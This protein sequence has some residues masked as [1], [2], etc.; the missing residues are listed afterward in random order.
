MNDTF[1]ILMLEDNHD[2]AEIIFNL[3]K[4]NKFYFESKL[5]SDK[6]GFV[7]AL[8]DFDPA[9]ILCDNSMPRFSATEALEVIRQRAVYIPFILITGSASEEFAADIIKKG[10]DDFILK[11]RLA[12]L[13]A[14]IRSA[15]QKRK[16]EYEMKAKE[17]QIMF[18]AKLLSAVGQAIIVTDLTDAVTYWNSAAEKMYGWLQDEV[19][20]RCITELVPS[21]QNKEHAVAI[22]EHM[23]Q[24]NSWRGDLLVQKKDGST[25]PAFV[26]NSPVYDR[27]GKLSGIISVSNDISEQK[28]ANEE[29]RELEKQIMESKIQHQKMI[30]RA[31]IKAQEEERNRLG[32]ELHDNISQILA[33]TILYLGA[34]AKK[35]KEI[36]GL[37]K[38]PISSI[39]NSVNEIRLL[40]ARYVTPVKNINLERQVE[41]LISQ[42]KLATSIKVLFIYSVV[43][44]LNDE[45]KLN[46]FRIVQ[47][48]VNNIIKHAA[49]GNVTI[50][51]EEAGGLL[52]VDIM[53][54]GRGFDPG[55][56]RNGIGISNMINRAE[57]FNGTFEIESS[58]GNGCRIKANIPV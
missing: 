26:T 23:K 38:F 44:Q 39:E 58:V 19:L 36:E 10:A 28:S 5:V 12:R 29:L 30:T 53:D 33:G 1:K 35:N 34:A 45:L 3:L 14:A 22:M 51:I 42:L 16:T 25:F 49:A 31:V 2:D 8:E 43:S 11:D 6:A 56:R 13:P 4:K 15:L 54:D 21:P 57:S 7:E 37:L 20:G 17:E 24:G 27:E 40:S 55:L 41:L 52:M 32:Q 48:Q 47:E 9:L 46:V 18:K 50:L